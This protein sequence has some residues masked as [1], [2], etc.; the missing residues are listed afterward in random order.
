[1]LR[2]VLFA[3]GAVIF[4]GAATTIRFEAPYL[5]TIVLLL[6]YVGTGAYFALRSLD[7][8]RIPRE[9]GRGGLPAMGGS[10]RWD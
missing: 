10:Q 8:L 7:A 2:V 1:M 9:R 3:L 4:F 5:S 6:L